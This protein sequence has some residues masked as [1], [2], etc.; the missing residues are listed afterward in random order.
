MAA[1]V[2]IGSQRKAAPKRRF[3]WLRWLAFAVLI[4]AVGFFFFVLS[5]PTGA[6]PPARADGIVV[7]TGGAARVGQA[8]ALL[9]HGVGKRLLI[10]GV[11]PATTK[12]DLKRVNGAGARFDC[13]TDLGFRAT[14]TRGNAVEAASWA[15][16]H[17]YRSLVVVT[18][19][20]HMPRSLNEFGAAM[21]GMRLEP[22]PVQPEGVDLAHWWQDAHTLRLLQGEYVKYLASLVASSLGSPEQSQ[23][24][25]RRAARGKSHQDS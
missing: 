8:E 25:D 17:R 15:R 13:C 23:P 21:P 1:H 7:L 9:E 11:D 14:D 12:A 22:Y 10:S 3:G 24:L 16:A 18:A 2:T 20:Y 19:N 5:L 6:A 4:Y